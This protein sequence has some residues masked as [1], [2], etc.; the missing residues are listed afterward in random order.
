[1]VACVGASVIGGADKYF[2]FSGLASVGVAASGVIIGD[3]S[4]E[5]VDK[6]S[7]FH[8]KLRETLRDKYKTRD[9]YQ[10]EIDRIDEGIDE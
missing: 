2:L 9:E 1:M 6:Y 4:L 5:R 10:R 7:T 3:E 8:R